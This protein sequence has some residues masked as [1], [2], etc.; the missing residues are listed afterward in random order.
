MLTLYRY[1]VYSVPIIY[2]YLNFKIF[3]VYSLNYEFVFNH[4]FI[5]LNNGNNWIDWIIEILNS[6]MLFMFQHYCSW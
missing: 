3:I 1:I 5:Y 6:E 2:S 4:L